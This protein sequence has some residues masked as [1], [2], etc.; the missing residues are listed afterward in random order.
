[1]KPRIASVPGWLIATAGAFAGIATA[2]AFAVITTA[3][4]LAETATAGASEQIASARFTDPT[5]RYGH[6]VLG[7]NAEWG[8]LEI[9]LTD[10]RKRK[11]ILPKS[12]V[13]EDLKPR[14]GD[15]DGDGRPELIVIETDVNL[16]AQLAIYGPQG[17]ITATP[18]IG[19]RFR[20][21]APLG[22]A[23]LDGDGKVEI[24]YID[25]PHL[26]KILSVWRYDKQKLTPVAEAPGLTNHKIG[27]DFI[28]G[29]IRDCGAGP[30]IITADAN[31]RQVVE[32]RFT[33]DRLSSRTI[34]PFNG[35]TSLRAA[36][37]C[38]G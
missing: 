27:Q 36:L 30:R 4:A 22:A 5:A 1:M 9:T 18:N 17:K 16:G 2:G 12:R 11:F 26:A 34:G 28:S 6:A 33:G 14:L 31:W 38:P 10:G 32:T 20:W 19:N 8:S 13:Y 35:L 29:G 3:G 21:L 24:A 15:L 37:K 7:D 25:R 23:D